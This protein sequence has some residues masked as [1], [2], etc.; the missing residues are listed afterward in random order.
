MPTALDTQRF[1]QGIFGH[2]IDEDYWLDS[3][4]N[5]EADDDRLAERIN[6]D[7]QN[8][9]RS[10]TSAGLSPSHPAMVYVD[11]LL[12]Q[13]LAFWD[14]YRSATGSAIRATDPFNWWN[15]YHDDLMSW[16]GRMSELVR[17]LPTLVPDTSQRA[18]V[19][20]QLEDRGVPERA[21]EYGRTAR[22]ETGMDS[23]T[24]RL[25][26]GF[27]AVGGLLTAGVWIATR[28]RR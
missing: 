17:R 24:K 16:A 3:E 19:E 12:Q 1:Y 4:W 2:E 11:R 27:V 26:L 15:D 9:W 10:G 5:H 22:G 18:E 7:L 23:R 21:E 25:L 6:N 14:D 13:W 28:R 20:T 8:L